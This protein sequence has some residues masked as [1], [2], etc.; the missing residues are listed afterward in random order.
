MWGFDIPAMNN[1]WDIW[2]QKQKIHK[3]CERWFLKD[4]AA[5]A[6]L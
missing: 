5:E 4:P 1:I 3:D 2:K 6:T